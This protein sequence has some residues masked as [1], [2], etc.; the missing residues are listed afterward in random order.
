[1][2]L[3]IYT[4]LIISILTVWGLVMKYFRT[5]S[6]KVVFTVSNISLKYREKNNGCH[7]FCICVFSGK[8]HKL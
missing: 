6:I 2:W 1:M 4:K 3:V 5:E 7:S 8:G